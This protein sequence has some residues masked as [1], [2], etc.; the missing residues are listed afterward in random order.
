MCN[1]CGTKV[2]EDAKFC[3]ACGAPIQN[4]SSADTKEMH[5]LQQRFSSLLVDAKEKIISVLGNSLAQT[6]LA[7]GAL[8]NGFAVL[9]DK[10]IYFKGKCLYRNGKWLRYQQEE[11]TVDVNDITGT[12]FVHNKCLWPLIVSIVAAY[13]AFFGTLMISL[14]AGSEDFSEEGMTAAMMPFSLF[15]VAAVIFYFIYRSQKRSLFEIS[16]AGGRIAFDL[17]WASL[18]EAQEFQKQIV[19][20]KQMAKDGP[21]ADVD[22]RDDVVAPPPPPDSSDKV[23]QLKQATELYQQG[24]ITDEQYEQL[25]KQILG[26]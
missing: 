2:V 3:P 17:K 18:A 6:F 26:M 12:G 15:S 5:P 13:L 7:T 24:V 9:T 1:Q 11:R 22:K 19:R 23:Q 25:K 4:V 21:S 16:F 14:N 8:G 10:R 20:T